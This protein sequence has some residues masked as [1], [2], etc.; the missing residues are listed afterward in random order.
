MTDKVVV[1]VTA[2][3]LKE[4]RTI[5][6]ALVEAR[7]AACVNLLPPVESLYHW[8]GKIEGSRERLLL[9]KTSREIFPELQAAI[10]RVHSYATPEIICL[11][12]IDGSR[13][14]L[15]WLGQSIKAESTPAPSPAEEPPAKA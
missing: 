15:E 1:L 2:G 12:I 11:P 9:I 8:K 7:L 3:S 10:R 14:Y 4:A 13:D 6:R 5:A